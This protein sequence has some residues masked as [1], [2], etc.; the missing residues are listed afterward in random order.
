MGDTAD[1]IAENVSP[2]NVEIIRVDGLE[3]A[4]KISKEVSSSG[5]SIILSPASA[6]FGM[7]R[8][9]AERGKMFQKFVQLYFN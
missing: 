5:D 8:N 3:E 4:I 2:L 7:F 1:K 6:S 9:F